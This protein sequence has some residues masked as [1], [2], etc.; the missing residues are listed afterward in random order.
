MDPEHPE[1]SK[2]FRGFQNDKISEF[3]EKTGDSRKVVDCFA[4]L[5]MTRLN[6]FRESFREN[7]FTATQSAP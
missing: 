4:G 2:I 6:Q 5:A 7:Y 3:L 1:K